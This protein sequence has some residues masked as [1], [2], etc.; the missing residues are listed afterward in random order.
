MAGTISGAGTGVNSATP[1]AKTAPIRIWPSPPMLKNW[2]RKASVRPAPVSSSGTAR[3]STSA[4]PWGSAS[5]PLNMAP[6]AS[7]GETP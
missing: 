4:R 7:S 6:Y 3:R 2:A 1:P 5:V